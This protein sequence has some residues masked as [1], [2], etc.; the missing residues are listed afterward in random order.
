MITERSIPKTDLDL[1]SKAGVPSTLVDVFKDAAKLHNRSNALNYKKG[2]EWT[3]ISSN[4]MLSR[5][6]QIA[7][8]LYQLGLERGDRIA[9]ISANCPEW[10]LTDAGAIFAGII[11]VPIYLTQA[12]AQVR[13]ILDDAG[14]KILFVQNEEVYNRIKDA[15]K[16]CASLKEVI[17]FDEESAKLAGAFSLTELEADGRAAD[18]SLLNEDQA[19]PE[20]LATIIYTSGTTGEPKGVMLTHSNLVSNLLAAAERLNLSKVESCLNVLPLSHVFERLAMYMYIYLGITVYYA[21]SI[22]KV[23]T[24]M[25]EV[26]PSLVVCVPRLF[27]KMYARIQEKAREGGYI[28]KTALHWAVKVGKEWAEETLNNRKPSS[29]LE[30]KHKLATKL[31]F[32]KWHEAMGGRMKLF[33]SGGAA[34]PPDLGYIFA[35]AGLPIIQ[36]YGLTETSPVIAACSLEENRIGTVGKPIRDVKVRIAEDGEIEV[37]G[38][39]IM[40]GYYNK[41]E[42]TRAVITEDGWFK[43]GD[44]GILDKDGFLSITDRKKDLFKT[45]GGK[46]ISP[47]H[48][49]DLLKTLGFVNQVVVIGEGRHFPAA[50]IVPNWNRVKHY[51]ELLG[52]KDDSP[53]ALSKNPQM[54]DHLLKRI[55][56]ASNDLGQYERIKRIAL[57]EKEFTVDGGELTPTLKVKRRVVNEKYKDIIESLYG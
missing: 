14:V 16:D 20:D 10:T 17:F 6:K 25:R 35:G 5:A 41:P 33:V 30:A 1:S 57:L 51:A 4:E 48:V 47:Q 24:N 15:I 13:Y 12:P 38:P 9:L 31:V 40:L 56:E 21:E 53:K 42:Q 18:P 43:T 29:L 50:L 44:I 36:G 2:N 45:S 54:I 7:L 28:K 34:L 22:E 23:A 26:K 55:D 3:P 39:N 37:S 19:K 11:N 27:E 52:I 32:S 8:G 46:Y 49:E